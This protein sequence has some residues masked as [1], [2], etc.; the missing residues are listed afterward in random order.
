MNQNERAKSRVVTGQPIREFL[1][2]RIL[3]LHAKLINVE[4]RIGLLK[5]KI[6]NKK[7]TRKI[8]KQ[9]DR[10]KQTC[11]QEDTHSQLTYEHLAAWTH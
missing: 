3:D 9:E 7:T 6:I 1:P 4:K 10:K 11:T 5:K 8:H 2:L